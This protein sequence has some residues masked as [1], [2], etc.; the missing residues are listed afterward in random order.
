MTRGK[1]VW[2]GEGR[3][4]FEASAAGN[5]VLHAPPADRGL[6]SYKVAIKSGAG[7]ITCLVCNMSSYNPNDISKLY[8]GFCHRFHTETLVAVDPVYFISKP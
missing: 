6:P 2:D 4:K 5:I 8:C 3:V 1:L 7:C